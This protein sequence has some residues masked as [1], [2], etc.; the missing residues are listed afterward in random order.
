M[1]I[2]VSTPYILGKF[3]LGDTSRELI[4]ESVSTNGKYKL[5]AYRINAGATVDWSVEVYLEKNGKDK[6]LVYNAYHESE[7]DIMWISN[8]KV[9]INGIKL[10]LDKGETFDWRR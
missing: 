10:N 2:S 6:I 5:S 8:N 3:L 4:L 1:L 9:S 7:A